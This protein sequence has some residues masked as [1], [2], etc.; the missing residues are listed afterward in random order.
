MLSGSLGSTKIANG[1]MRGAEISFTA[2]GAQYTGRVNGSSIQGTMTGGS[3][4]SWTAT[5]V[6]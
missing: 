3:G 5:K 4:A 1:R 6:R 2:G